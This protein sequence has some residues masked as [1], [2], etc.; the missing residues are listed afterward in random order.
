MIK[1]YYQDDYATIYHG[2][3][4]EIL[5]Q[6]GPVDLVLTDPPYN[7]KKDYGTFKDDLDPEE[8]AAFMGEVVS[9]CRRLALKQFWVAPRYQLLL[10]TGLLPDSHLI[11]IRRGAGGPYR[12]GWSDQFEIALAVGKPKK[13]ISDLWDDIRLK[14]EGYY[15]RE[16]TYGHPGYTPSAIF[17]RAIAT[18]GCNS[19][20]DPFAGTGTSLFCAKRVGLRAIGIEL[21]ERYCEIA[22]NRMRQ[23]I[24]FGEA[25]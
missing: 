9:E 25:A 7:A 13:V 11:V 1:P 17:T 3:C 21:N 12:G 20:V 10:W 16:E 4:R 15:F 2:D 22:A 14:G 8:Y 19:I 18:Y 23:E 24:L 5:P 6:L